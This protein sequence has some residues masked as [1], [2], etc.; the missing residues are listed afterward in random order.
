MSTNETEESLNQLTV[1]QLKELLAQ[2]SLAR[3]GVKKELIERL[4]NPPAPKAKTPPKAS[5]TSKTPPKEPSSPKAQKVAKP[6][7]APKEPKVK[8]AKA[9]KEP[10]PPKEPKAPKE[11]VNKKSTILRTP[12]EQA[13]VSGPELSITPNYYSPEDSAKI[14]VNLQR[15][16]YESSK[17]NIR[18]KD[19]E[20]SVKYAWFS[21]TGL[22]YVFGKT[23]TEPLTVQIL[24][25]YPILDH[26]RKAVEDSTGQKFN[27]LLIARYDDG[28]TKLS[29]HHDNDAWLGESFIVPS[30]SFGA[31]RR[32]LVK[33][34]KP[35]EASETVVF[36][37]PLTDGSLVIMGESMQKTWQ[38][39]I[40]AQK[41]SAEDPKALTGLRFNLTFRNVHPE[42]A[43]KMPKLAKTAAAVA[44]SS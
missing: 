40:P 12:E 28:A 4:L 18:G 23:M 16:D 11:K 8:V 25:D 2:R 26:I 22:P 21:D 14:F 33:L 43:E 7:K 32:F 3:N 38:H 42:L 15:I 41:F 39:S 20:S 24:D 27:S 31:T 30:L 37:Y 1:V 10:K 29:Y 17:H 36:E 5:A 34:R 9:P 19:G 44:S 6:P 13:T 35:A